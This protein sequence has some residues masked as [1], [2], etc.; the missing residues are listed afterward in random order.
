M[1]MRR[2][3]TLAASAV[4]A[5][6][7]LA[8]PA[9]LA[10]PRHAAQPS[11]PSVTSPTIGHLAWVTKGEK[12]KLAAVHRN[13]STSAVKTIGPVSTVSG[14]RTVQVF[15][16][17]ASG[18][19]NWLAW[20]ELVLSAGGN[21]V[22]P[23]LLVVRDQSSGKVIKI[24]T[25]QAPVGFAGDRLITSDAVVTKRLVLT[26]SPHLVKLFSDQD[27]LATYP[28]GVVEAI[29]SSKPRGPSQTWKVELRSL[30][31]V[32]TVLHSYVLSPTNYRLPEQAWVSADGKH[33]LV[34]RGDHTD[35]DG[36]GP[37]S[38][39]D[40]FR[41]TGG[42]A[43][44]QLGH[45]GTDAAKWRVAAVTFAGKNDAVWAVWER[46]TKT[47][48]T[49]VVARHA[50]GTWAPVLNHGIAVAANHAGFKVVQPGKYVSVGHDAPQFDPVPTRHALLRHH[51]SV[52]TLDAEGS[53]FAWV[54][55]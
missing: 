39:T 14:K 54:S 29:A 48:A 6:G 23:P 32:R 43:R 51:G 34:E 18:D 4:T 26:P 22:G 13:G 41:L 47:G 45:Y 27:S 25:E 8:A 49:T 2:S 40:E 5:C 28:A 21:E 38:L 31:G 55:G 16:F 15:D 30:G 9:A 33:L 52:R 3:V 42:H 46:G 36:L 19:G 53:V 7:L 37:S 44:T 20:E 10:A 35:F 1:R 11:R 17:M 12:V 24:A 50:D